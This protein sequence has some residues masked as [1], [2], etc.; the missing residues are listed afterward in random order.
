LTVI[1]AAAVRHDP[2]LKRAL[3]LYG[4]DLGGVALLA[5][6]HYKWVFGDKKQLDWLLAED[7][8]NGWGADS[9]TI[10]VFAYMDEWD[11]TIRALKEPDAYLRQGEGGATDEILY[12]AIEIRK[13]LYGAERFDKAWKAA[14]IK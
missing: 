4:K 8:K 9:L 10:M 2:K 11:K 6:A 5:V 12:R 14:N 13:R 1:N 7:R 3:D